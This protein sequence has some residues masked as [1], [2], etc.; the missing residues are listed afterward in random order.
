MNKLLLTLKV[1][2]SVFISIFIFSQSLLAQKAEI[3]IQNG[4]PVVYNP[5]EPSPP[6]NTPSQLTL[7]EDLK[8]GG[9]SEAHDYPFSLISFLVIDEDENMIVLDNGESCVKIFDKTGKKISQFAREGEG[10]G[11][12]QSPTTLTVIGN[13][14]IGV[15]DPSNHRFTYFA[16]DGTILKEIILEKYWNVRRVKSDNQGNIY[17]NFFTVVEAEKEISFTVDLIKF[18]QDFKPAM[19]LASFEHSRKL[20][21]VDM[22]EKRFG[23]AVKEDNSLVWG[24]NT[25]YILHVVNPDGQI[26]RKIVKDYNPVK[27]TKEEREIMYHNR[28]GDR[29]LPSDITLNYPKYFPAYYYVLCDSEGRIYVRTY[30]KTDQREDFY[31]V[32]DAEGRYITNF[33]LPEDDMLFGI[34][35]N[36]AYVINREDIPSLTRYTMVWE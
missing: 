4:I 25:D 6:P 15:I 28:F 9:E 26:V 10:P 34:K 32:F 13:N 30:K 18:D 33:T 2:L 31:D 14:K 1:I 20:R 12:F 36:K 11:E 16:Q 22:T 3:K 35:N 21:E 29:E 24:V 8:L 19:T 23:Y 27:I 5:K 7:K 17:A